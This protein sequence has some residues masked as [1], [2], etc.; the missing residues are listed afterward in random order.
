MQPFVVAKQL[1]MEG[2]LVNQF[3]DRTQEGIKQN[4]K[5]V[6]EGKLKYKEYITDGFE[7]ASEAFIGLFKGDNT[8]K[9]LVKVN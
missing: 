2:F 6:K 1:K 8:G 4:L 7:T 3:A 9:T 5:W